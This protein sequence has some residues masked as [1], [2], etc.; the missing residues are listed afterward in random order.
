MQQVFKSV[1]ECK[2][3][4]ILSPYKLFLK[5]YIKGNPTINTSK[6]VKHA[7]YIIKKIITNLLLKDLCLDELEK[8]PRKLQD[9]KLL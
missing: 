7:P 4:S 2:K 5:S 1:F 6:K 3:E 8:L 9:L